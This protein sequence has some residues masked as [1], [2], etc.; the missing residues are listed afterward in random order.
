MS[1]CCELLGHSY[2]SFSHVNFGSL[3][4]PGQMSFLLT[5]N[6][7]V[8]PFTHQVQSSTF[9]PSITLEGEVRPSFSRIPLWLP[10]SPLRIHFFPTLFELS[11]WD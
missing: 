9:L 8:S 5:G 11:P 7:R 10:L 6:P 2:D 3:L 1:L 4:P